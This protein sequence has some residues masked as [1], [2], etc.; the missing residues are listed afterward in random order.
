MSQ[1]TQGQMVTYEYRCPKCQKL[2]TVL[3]EMHD[4]HKY[5]CPSDKAKCHMVFTVNM[6]T[7]DRPNGFDD[8]INMGL[9]KHFESTYQ[10]DEF[11][12]RN[13]MVKA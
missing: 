1:G 4:E 11:A 12:K 3:Q 9:G 8:G 13:G 6:G 10:R 2:Y 5:R 7:I